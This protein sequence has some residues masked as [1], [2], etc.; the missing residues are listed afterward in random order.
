[1]YFSNIEHENIDDMLI[2][3][4]VDVERQILSDILIQTIKKEFTEK[5]FEIIDGLY[6]QGISMRGELMYSE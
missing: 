6:I 3:Y 4:S 2:D 1:M 5:E